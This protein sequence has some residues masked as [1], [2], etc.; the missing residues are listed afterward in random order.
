MGAAC[1]HPSRSF[2]DCVA[3][4]VFFF[5]LSLSLS[6]SLV[7]LFSLSLTLAHTFLAQPPVDQEKLTVKYPD[8]F[9]L[10]ESLRGMG[11]QSADLRYLVRVM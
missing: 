7:F 4:L 10:M 11:E 2:G 1:A 8:A 5:T 9:A 6:L 3:F